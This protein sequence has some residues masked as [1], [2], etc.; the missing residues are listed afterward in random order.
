MLRPKDDKGPGEGGEDARILEDALYRMMRRTA[1]WRVYEQVAEPPL[2]VIDT[3]YVDQSRKLIRKA[4]SFLIP[5]LLGSM[6]GLAIVFQR[7]K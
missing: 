4:T 6:A 7:R 5:A 2:W 1:E 3:P